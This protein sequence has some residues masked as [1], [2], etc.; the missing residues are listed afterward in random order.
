[1]WNRFVTLKGEDCSNGNPVHGFYR[2]I[3]FEFCL[4]ERLCNHVVC[5]FLLIL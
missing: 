3:V 5:G 2:G 1:M 4:Q